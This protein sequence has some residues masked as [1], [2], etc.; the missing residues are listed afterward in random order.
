LGGENL[1][2][3][4]QPS[5]DFNVIIIGSGGPPYDPK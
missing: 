2:T 3:R 5:A 4:F 1:P